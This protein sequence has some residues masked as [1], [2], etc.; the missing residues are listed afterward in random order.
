MMDL[1]AFLRT[2]AQAAKDAGHVWP[3]YAACE[4][5]VESAWGQS[6]LA[7]KANNLFGQKQS[8]PPVEGSN[9]T[10][11]LPTKEYVHGAWEVVIAQWATFPDWAS[12]IRARM[13]L[14]RRLAA[15]NDPAGKPLYPGYIAALAATSGEEFITLVSATWSTGPQRGAEVLG[16]YRQHAAAFEGL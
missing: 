1:N 11:E 10:M 7:V 14:L 8:H 9:G 16:I 6:S 3:A 5:A 12:A 2:A 4:V 15:A 13:A